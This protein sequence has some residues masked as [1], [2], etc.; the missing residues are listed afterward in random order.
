MPTS[1][2]LDH[3]HPSLAAVYSEAKASFI[4]AH[5]GGLVPRLGETYRSP[6]VQR[7]YY[8]QGR[9]P[10]AEINRL[11]TRAGLPLI[12]TTEAG[13]IITK[14]QP[15][16]SAHGFLPARAFDVLLLNP[17]GTANWEQKSYQLFAGFVQAAAAKLNVAVSIGA[18]WKSFPDAPHTQLAAWRTM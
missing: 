5:P 3:L 15:G 13:R 7:A 8:A 2:R 6:E 4:K 10:L 9:Q 11:R 18:F 1:N 14:A 16:Q 12:G 17:N